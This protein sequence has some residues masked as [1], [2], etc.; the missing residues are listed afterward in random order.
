M[1]TGNLILSFFEVSPFVYRAFS[2]NAVV[3]RED[4]NEEV[5]TEMKL[6]QPLNRD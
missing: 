2:D 3:K 1:A 6:N 5:G 4:G